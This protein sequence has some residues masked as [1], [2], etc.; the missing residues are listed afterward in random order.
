MVTHAAEQRNQ[1]PSSMHTAF[2]AKV[3]ELKRD[4][5]DMVTIVRILCRMVTPSVPEC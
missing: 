5:I 3:E 2:G 4:Q 1:L